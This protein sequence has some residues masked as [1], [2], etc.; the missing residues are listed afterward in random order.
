VTVWNIGYYD[1]LMKD[2]LVK[3]FQRNT[4]KGLV[5]THVFINGKFRPWQLQIGDIAARQ[6]Q[7]GDYGIFNRQPTLRTESMQGVKLNVLEGEE[8]REYRVNLCVC[9]TYNADFDGDECN[10]HIP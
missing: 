7:S 5:I 2:G 1:K 10:L 6:L 3:S 4:P 8:N 9:T